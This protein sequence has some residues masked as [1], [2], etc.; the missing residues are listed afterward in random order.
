MT[1]STEN[2]EREPGGV[3]FFSVNLKWASPFLLI[4]FALWVG[5]ILW[6]Y[7]SAG[8]TPFFSLSLWAKFFPPIWKI[9]PLVFVEHLSRFLKL[10]LF[11]GMAWGIGRALLLRLLRLDQLNPFEVF[12]FGYGLG[13]G[14][15]GYLMLGLGA[16]GLLRFPIVLGLSFLLCLLTFLLNRDLSIDRI[17]LRE[18]G[19]FFFAGFWKVLSFSL[20]LFIFLLYGFYALV[21]EIFYDSLVYHLALPQ[22]Y[23]IEGR[24]VST[25]TI[26]YSGIPQLME[27][28]YT[29]ALFMD[30]GIL[31]KLIHWSTGIG[32]AVG[33]L[34][35]SLRCRKPLMGWLVCIILF[36]TPLVGIN[37]WKT[38]V[39]VG[40]TYMVLLSI[41]ALAL[42]LHEGKGALASR[43][44]LILS[45]V[46]AGLAMGIKYTNWPLLAVLIVCFL[47]LRIS[48]RT[49]SIYTLIVLAIVAPWVIKNLWFYGNPI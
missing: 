42:Y 39:D 2:K 47:L 43:S 14:V 11:M 24:L 29:W 44:L 45:A 15:M 19:S 38:G 13:I 23:Q 46:N 10:A 31:A 33:L 36:S 40:S 37:Q 12:A 48:L 20:V 16:L 35:L 4:P 30:D 1:K 6:T 26:L 32:F 8:R 41:Y 9:Q 7:Y 34:G 49:I 28:L 18:F 17:K 21:P 3:D 22:L 25:P 5:Y 27:M